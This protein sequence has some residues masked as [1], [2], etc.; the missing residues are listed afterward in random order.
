MKS[1]ILLAAL[2]AGVRARVTEPVR[3]RDHT[4]RMLRA[5]GARVSRIPGGVALFLSLL[6][7]SDH[8]PF[9]V[10]LYAVFGLALVMRA[11]LMAR[12]R[13][14]RADDVGYPP[15]ISLSFLHFTTWAALF[16]VAAAWIAPVGHGHWPPAPTRACW[17]HPA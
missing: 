8:L 12:M 17:S 14:W 13:Q 15:L 3:S 10:F 1:A 16:L 4:E 7:L 5:L 11:N 2:G 6:F 9:A